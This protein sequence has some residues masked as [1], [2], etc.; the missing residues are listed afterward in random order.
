MSFTEILEYNFFSVG[1]FHLNLWNLIVLSGILFFTRMG[2]WFIN[3]Y[4]IGAV[5]RKKQVDVGRRYALQQFVKYFLYTLGILMALQSIGI[6]L[7]VIWAG[8]A[9]LLVGLGM[10]LQQTFNDLVSGIILLFE[11]TVAVGDMVLV[12]GIVGKVTQIGLRT[13]KVETRDQT[14]IIIPNSKLVTD[15]VINWSHTDVPTR[16]KVEVGVSY[17][18]DVT[19]VEKLLLQEAVSQQGVLADPRPEVQ[20]QNFGDSALDF[21]V[22]F[23]STDYLQ[24]EAIKSQLRFKIFVAFR[25]NKVEIPFPQQDIWIRNADE[26]S[27]GAKLTTSLKEPPI[28]IRTSD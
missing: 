9:A 15:N 16:F 8:S 28:G 25:Q 19:Q 12:D 4:F 23:Y 20:F 26:L 17:N 7:S 6:H 10:G 14:S 13:S 27:S 24:I 11:G 5:A 3:R 2:V 18:S 21:S 22:Y 1:H